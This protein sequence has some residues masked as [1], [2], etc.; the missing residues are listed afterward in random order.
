MK[1]TGV[2]NKNLVVAKNVLIFLSPTPAPSLKGGDNSSAR[3][4]TAPSR[5]HPNILSVL[6]S[7]L[8]K[9]FKWNSIDFLS[10]YTKY[11]ISFEIAIVKTVNL[12]EQDES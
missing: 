4:L 6:I 7:P 2:F 11:V 8:L 3:G 1:F 10:S 9:I 5:F 12:E